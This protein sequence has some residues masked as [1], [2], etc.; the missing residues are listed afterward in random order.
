MKLPD[1]GGMTRNELFNLFLQRPEPWLYQLLRQD[2]ALKAMMDRKIREWFDTTIPSIAPQE[3]PGFPLEL[4]LTAGFPDAPKRF[5]R[6]GALLGTNYF[7]GIMD[8]RVDQYF[9]NPGDWPGGQFQE[10]F[11]KQNP[12]DF[13]FDEKTGKYRLKGGPR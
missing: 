2:E 6:L 10:F 1:Q 3:A 12:D 13:V 9:R 7:G 4:A 11:M 5:H 8:A